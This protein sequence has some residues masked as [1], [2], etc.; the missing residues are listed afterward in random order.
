MFVVSAG[1]PDG[2][3]RVYSFNGVPCEFSIALFTINISYYCTFL[4]TVDLIKYNYYM[5]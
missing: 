4:I 5:L 1:W 2:A 3:K